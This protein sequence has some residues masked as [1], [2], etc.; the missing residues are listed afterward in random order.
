M[1]NINNKLIVAL[2]LLIFLLVVFIIKPSV[3]GYSIY[4][5][6]AKLNVTLDELATDI[7]KY[8]DELKAK[9]INLSVCNSFNQR[10]LSIIDNQTNALI[11]YKTQITQL[12]YNL[13]KSAKEVKQKNKRISRLNEI[14]S[15][16]VNSFNKRLEKKEDML[17]KINKSYGALTAKYNSLIKNIGRKICCKKKVDN[18]NIKFFSVTDSNIVCLTNSTDNSYALSCDLL[19]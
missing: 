8:Q 19:D 3:I 17:N 4:K 15:N 14:L 16:K 9:S 18:P 6:T 1:R 12:N 13:S 11:Y 10:L 7:S 2:L 5:K